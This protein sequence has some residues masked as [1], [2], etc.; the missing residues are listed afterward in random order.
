MSYTR[1]DSYTWG[2]RVSRVFVRNCGMTTCDNTVPG[3]Q[4]RFVNAN[5]KQTQ[6]QWRMA[7]ATVTRDSCPK[8][9]H[10]SNTR[11]TRLSSESHPALIT[12]KKE[13]W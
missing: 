2:D 4:N 6:G 13:Q 12:S 11:I 3:T 8:Q 1:T 10:N 5:G 9:T 7:N